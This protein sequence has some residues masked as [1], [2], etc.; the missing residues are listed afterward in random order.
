MDLTNQARR[1]RQGGEPRQPILHRLNVVGYLAD[2]GHL[3]LA[4]PG[5][6][7]KKQVRKGSSSALDSAG[8]HRFAAEEGTDQEMRIRKGT[9]HTRE[10]AE[11]SVRL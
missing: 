4:E 1:H 10:L 3:L 9:R 11:S 7:K 8:K 6:L 2:I 5:S